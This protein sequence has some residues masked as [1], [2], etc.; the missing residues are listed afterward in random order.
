[1]REQY[2]AD[3][4][5]HHVEQGHY[6]DYLQHVFEQQHFDPFVNS[7]L[8]EFRHMDIAIEEKYAQ[9]VE[10]LSD[11]VRDIQSA[12]EPFDR[13][14]WAKMAN[15]YYVYPRTFNLKDFRLEQ[16][17]PVPESDAFFAELD[18]QDLIFIRDQRC[19][20]SIWFEGMSP[21]GERNR[22]G[23]AGGS[24]YSIR[25]PLTINP[26]YGTVEDFKRVVNLMHK[27]GMKVEVGFVP[28]HTAM[29]SVLLTENPKYFVHKVAEAGEQPPE[30]AFEYNH[31]DG[32]R[33][34]I[35]HGAFDSMGVH[36]FF[37]DTAQLDYSNPATRRKMIEIAETMVREWGV[38][39]F[40]IDMSYCVTQEYFKRT[41][42]DR[43]REKNNWPVPDDEPDTEFLYELYSH[44]KAICP[45]FATWHEAY[46][47]WNTL[48]VAGASVIYG[49]NN[50]AR[51][52]GAEHFGYYDAV[53]SLLPE[54]I[55]EVLRRTEFLFWQR[56]GPSALLF[57]GNHDE[58]ALKRKMGER[59]WKG[60][61]TF[62]ALLPGGRLFQAGQEIGTDQADKEIEGDLKP[63]PFSKR[64]QIDWLHPDEEHVSL[65]EKLNGLRRYHTL[66]NPR[67]AFRA[68]RDMLFEE[69]AWVGYEVTTNSQ[70]DAGYMVLWNPTNQF[71]DFDFERESSGVYGGY[72]SAGGYL[73]IDLTDGQVLMRDSLSHLGISKRQTAQH[74]IS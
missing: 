5:L 51:A 11:Y 45:W 32:K 31:T 49:K 3:A 59:Y 6:F 65:Y 2:G 56:G 53:A 60:V 9:L 55:R 16:G 54:N 28:N 68:L 35:A 38:D 39:G 58:P 57:D 67:V 20:D 40:R 47:K 29:D 43:F 44:I 61:A 30:G 23:D 66:R 18:E 27:L 52:R 50:I 74:A 24:P 36:N 48:S 12:V 70:K 63:L 19:M 42:N 34:F 7:A 33:Y 41:W 62:T 25:D 26:D 17:R 37:T 46:D 64:S 4:L 22:K 10:F 73:V 69:T 13:A 21:I 71:C 1:M 15:V 72:L 14:Q 8:R